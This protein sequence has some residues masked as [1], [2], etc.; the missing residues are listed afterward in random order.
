M[1][2][3]QTR[4]RVFM[5]LVISTIATFTNLISSNG[6]DWPF[7]VTWSFFT[8]LTTSPLIGGRLLDEF[9]GDVEEAIEGDLEEG[10]TDELTEET[11]E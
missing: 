2:V 3:Y 5:A 6:I 1:T 11:Q 4:R 9:E 10:E 8:F 7:L